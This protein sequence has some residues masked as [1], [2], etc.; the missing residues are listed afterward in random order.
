ML[1][2]CRRHVFNSSWLWSQSVVDQ[3]F[4]TL[5]LTD[6][7]TE[8]QFHILKHALEDFFFNLTIFY[9]NVI[10]WQMKSRL[11]FFSLQDLV[12]I[13]YLKKIWFSFS[14]F[15][16]NDIHFIHFDLILAR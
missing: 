13:Q 10:S 16:F 8:D 12:Q 2:L 9:H 5:N 15:F 6:Q 11:F 7:W 14:F 1:F 4:Q 3:T